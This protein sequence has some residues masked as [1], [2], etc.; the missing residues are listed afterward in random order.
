MAW[1]NT[2]Q[3][4]WSSSSNNDWKAAG[5]KWPASSSSSSSAWHAGSSSTAWPS[6]S[7]KDRPW[8]TQAEAEAGAQLP[9]SFVQTDKYLDSTLVNNYPL[10]R[11]VESTPWSR[12]KG[13]GGK[14]M[15][16]VSAADLAYYGLEESSLRHLS[17][18]RFTSVIFARNVSE[19]VLLTNLLS[20]IRDGPYN[21]DQIAASC[22]KSHSPAQE[23]PD[24]KSH[25]KDFLAPLVR[26]MLAPFRKHHQTTVDSQAIE[27]V[28]QLEAQVAAMK[29]SAANKGIALSPGP[30]RSKSSSAASSPKT[31][32][33]LFPA[34]SPKED[35]P[36]APSKGSLP[37]Q[38]SE[39]V[40]QPPAKKAKKQ[41]EH[42][43]VIRQISH[44]TSRPLDNTAPKTASPE[45]VAKWV[46]AVKKTLSPEK[47]QQLDQ[48]VGLIQASFHKLLKPQKPQLPDLAA[49]Y[50]LPVSLASKLD[51][52]NL[53]HVV[54][55]ASFLAS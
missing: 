44:P 17:A 3:E 11:T 45:S 15:M 9:A 28:R 1:R 25:A 24:K 47:A 18:G 42:V 26:D 38:S 16:K 21:I 8:E 4:E 12:K 29:T 6:S 39:E 22:F 51:E 32:V 10:F 48:H 49:K 52:K 35:Q 7:S 36:K 5:D 41:A 13:L 33:S 31:P 30:E 54:A 27:M 34:A 46:T 14:D 55:V 23:V 37:V 40:V 20:A 19:A 2:W 43:E 50:G 53:L